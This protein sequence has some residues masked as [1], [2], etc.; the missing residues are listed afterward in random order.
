M[1]LEQSYFM[2]ILFKVFHVTHTHDGD[3]MLSRLNDKIDSVKNVLD[4]DMDMLKGEIQSLKNSL[5]NTKNGATSLPNQ[6]EEQVAELKSELEEIKQQNALILDSYHQRNVGALK[7]AIKEEKN[8]RKKMNDT[9]II[10]MKEIDDNIN[11]LEARVTELQTNQSTGLVTAEE[12]KSV[13]EKLA[14]VTYSV[15]EVQTNMEET[16]QNKTESLNETISKALSEL[17]WLNSYDKPSGYGG[18]CGPTCDN[19]RNSECHE[20]KC[21]CADGYI[22][23]QL[24]GCV[25]A[26]LVYGYA[27]HQVEDFSFETDRLANTHTNLE[28]CQQSCINIREKVCAGVSI[29]QGGSCWLMAEGSLPDELQLMI[30]D[31]WRAVIRF[32]QNYERDCLI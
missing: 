19:L 7:N 9:Y 22:F 32:R 1:K 30:F 18:D 17:D 8:L 13:N 2:I 12:L 26:C 27:F 23:S 16:L 29:S 24:R 15:K 4:F 28:G 6:C 25:K 10:K 11:S 14:I 5:T 20:F 3:N 21:V 31:W